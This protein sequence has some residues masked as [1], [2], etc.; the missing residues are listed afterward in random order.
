MDLA[1]D[2]GSRLLSR[3]WRCATAESCTGGLIGHLLTEV[4]G[5][6]QYYQ[7]GVVAYDN[8][9]KEGILGVSPET[10][11]AHGAVSDPCAREMAAGARRLMHTDAAVATTG[12]A[13]P[14]GGSADK[15]VGLVYIA[16][17]TPDGVTCE[18]H[19]FEGDRSGIKLATARRALELLLLALER[20][21]RAVVPAGSDTAPVQQ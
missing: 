16:V 3:G 21:D 11:K 13:G 6:S 1:Q 9:V 19:V 4:P 2:A 20:L 5:S 14:G 10:L 18:R 8:S 12:L 17:V 15:P 7:G